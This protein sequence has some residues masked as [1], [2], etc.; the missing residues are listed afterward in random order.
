MTGAYIENSPYIFVS[1]KHDAADADVV[2]K[3]ISELRRRYGFNIWY[4]A[5]LTAGTNWDAIA[6]RRV[7][8]SYC[9]M[10]LFFA[11]NA[12]LTSRPISE[13]LA[14]AKKWR[15]M[16]IPIS[17]E[18]RPFSEILMTINE[19]YN[20]SEPD[21]VDIADRIIEEHLDD[22]LTYIVAD[23]N[24]DSYYNDIF[25]TV[26]KNA[27]EIVESAGAGSVQEGPD[28]RE[29]RQTKAED[30][31]AEEKTQGEGRDLED[32]EERRSKPHTATGNITFTL[33]GEKRTYNQSDMMLTFFAQVLNRHQE[34]VEGLPG[35]KG[36]NCASA[37][38]YTKKENRTEEMPP[39]FRVCQ[40]FAFDSGCGVCIG[41]AYGINE[42]LKKMAMLLDICGEDPSV[43]S[44]EQVELPETGNAGNAAAV[45]YK[46][47]GRSFSS[48][49]T[50]M[51]GNIFR[52][53]IERHPDKLSELADQLVC[54][55]ISDYGKV[56]KKQR[57]VYFTSLCVYDL[58]GVTY[59]VGGT[60]SMAEKLKQIAKLLDICG[61]DKSEVEIEGYELPEA[62]KRK[63]SNIRYL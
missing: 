44:S 50:E 52:E 51:M 24:S 40:Y 1:Y 31:P 26:S 21:K 53:V 13:E 14:T 15:K 18:N 8:S 37:V 48:S 41:T 35:Q 42:K 36:M 62:G 60:F 6:L 16:I 57:P 61:V 59:S 28:G 17:F 11:S 32:S 27:P 29:D 9:K 63:K 39:Y 7:R 2:R 56:P 23:V 12:A 22:K 49:Q 33:Y 55:A 34:Y 47:Y 58:K 5:E 25:R 43:F 10:V 46:I 20:E 4:D 45:I 19:E 38:D 3:T 30:D 54:V